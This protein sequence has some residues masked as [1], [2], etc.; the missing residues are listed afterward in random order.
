VEI[1]VR[2]T[3][4]RAD[5]ELSLELANKVWPQYAVS[6]DEV[7]SFKAAVL[8]HA[9]HVAFV[10]TEP[11]G[12]GFVAI[13]PERPSTSLALVTPPHSQRWRSTT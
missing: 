13:Q 4:S 1:T 8:A 11:A 6:M 3:A 7:D 10:G 2:R 5:E 12:S 9:D